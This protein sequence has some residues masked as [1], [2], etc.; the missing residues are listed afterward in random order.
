MDIFDR[1]EQN[2][3]PLGAFADYAEGKYA[4]PQLE[5]EISTKMKFNGKEMLIFSLNNYLGLANHPEVR[6]TDEDAAAKFGLAYP[7]GSRAMTAQTKFHI[8]LEEELATFT[9]KEASLVLNFGYQGMFSLIDTLLSRNDVVIYDS[10]SHACA[11]DGIRLHR[12]K[13]FSFSH[14]DISSLEKVLENQ[15]KSPQKQEVEF[16]F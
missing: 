16:W 12:G 7:M 13:H 8:Q 11:I 10:E 6:K 3:G 9:E 15:K 4:F 5:G 14:N 1:I 2:P